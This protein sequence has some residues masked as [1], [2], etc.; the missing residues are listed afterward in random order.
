MEKDFITIFGAN[1]AEASFPDKLL[2][3]SFQTFTSFLNKNSAKPLLEACGDN[4]L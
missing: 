1:K 2:Y 3:L 4:F